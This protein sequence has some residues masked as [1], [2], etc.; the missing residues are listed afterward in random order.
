MNFPILLPHPILAFFLVI[1]GILIAMAIYDAVQSRRKYNEFFDE[2]EQ[3]LRE[4]K[5]K[6]TK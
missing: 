6:W 5:D 1:V 2:L 3:K 4:D